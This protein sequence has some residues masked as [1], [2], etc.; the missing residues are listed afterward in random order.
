MRSRLLANFSRR[1]S[2]E[3][4][5]GGSR[6]RGGGVGLSVGRLQGPGAQ[7]LNSRQVGPLWGRAEASRVGGGRRGAKRRHEGWSLAIPPGRHRP[8]SPRVGPGR[9]G[10][11]QR[12]CIRGECWRSPPLPAPCARC[13]S[14][15]SPLFSLREPRRPQP[16][17]LSP[18]SLGREGLRGSYFCP[19]DSVEGHLM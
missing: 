5:S 11:A 18:L 8:R 13:F 6:R 12:E 10:P 19:F 4:R 9:A 1:G 7:D 14:L 16:P 15:Y 2:G 3:E 17:A